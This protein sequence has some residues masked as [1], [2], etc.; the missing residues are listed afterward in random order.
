MANPE[1]TWATRCF[2]FRAPDCWVLE[3][4]TVTLRLYVRGGVVVEAVNEW[5]SDRQELD[6]SLV[7]CPFT[8]DAL[9]ER[10]AD[11]ELLAEFNRRLREFE[12]DQ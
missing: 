8:P 1:S 5:C 11:P 3:T 2:D 4:A 9:R 10:I 12:P 7:G 6:P